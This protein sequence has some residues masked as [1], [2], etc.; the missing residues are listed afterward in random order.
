MKEPVGAIVDRDETEVTIWSQRKKKGNRKTATEGLLGCHT[1]RTGEGQSQE[2]I[3]SQRK[4]ARA[5]D[6]SSALMEKQSPR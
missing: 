6:S 4:R 2:S 3:L 5:E 1:R